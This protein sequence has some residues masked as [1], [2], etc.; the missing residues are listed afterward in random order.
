VRHFGRFFYAI[1]HFIFY[2]TFNDFD[3]RMTSPLQLHVSYALKLQTVVIFRGVCNKPSCSIFECF[4]DHSYILFFMVYPKRMRWSIAVQ[5]YV[6]SSN[7]CRYAQNDRSFR[8]GYLRRLCSSNQINR[9]STQQCTL[10]I[11]LAYSWLTV[12]AS[13]LLCHTMRVGSKKRRVYTG[14]TQPWPYTM[15]QRLTFVL[16]TNGMHTDQ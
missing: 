1:V 5:G 14:N 13:R 6:A 16:W 7:N 2:C 4:T 3:F 15:T 11:D 8:L 9:L 10:S 12:A